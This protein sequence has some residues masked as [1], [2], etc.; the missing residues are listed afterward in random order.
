MA[1]SFIRLM[2]RHVARFVR[3]R[4]VRRTLF[5]RRTIADRRWCCVRWRSGARL[6]RRGFGLG[7]ISF[8]LF[9]G[10]ELGS[11]GRQY[12]CNLRGKALH[13]VDRAQG[14]EAGHA[15]RRGEVPG[16]FRQ[17]DAVADRGTRHPGAAQRGLGEI[18]RR[19]R[20]QER[21]SRILGRSPRVRQ[22]RRGAGIA[23]H[24]RAPAA[25]ASVF[26]IVEGGRRALLKTGTSSCCE[27]RRLPCPAFD[28]DRTTMLVSVPSG[29]YRQ[30]RPCT[31]CRIRRGA[32]CLE[33]TIVSSI[34]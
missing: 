22:S 34:A 4:V 8:Y 20:A 21:A 19:A 24:V 31:R 11:D 15:A 12:A 2:R 6:L 14:L 13:V 1:A 27:R 5:L 23:A 28:F 32:Y 33:I 30:N 7:G 18:G 25:Q 16:I 10:H 26:D 17:S 9:A 3:S 29:T